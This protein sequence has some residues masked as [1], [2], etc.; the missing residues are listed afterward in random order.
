MKYILVKWLLL[1][2]LNQVGFGQQ[3]GLLQIYSVPERICVE[4]QV[5]EDL[6]RDTSNAFVTYLEVT[7]DALIADF[8]AASSMVNCYPATGTFD[9]KTP[10]T[11]LDYRLS[12]NLNPKWEISGTILL[13]TGGL[14]KFQE[15]FLR[16][17]ELYNLIHLW[18]E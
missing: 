9:H 10:R 16:N 3:R 13:Y 4:G 2:T 1:L 18:C 8:L 14:L 6:I 15:A 5:T 12:S 17:Y 11:I 7:E